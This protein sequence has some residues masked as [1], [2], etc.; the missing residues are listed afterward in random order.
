MQILQ[1]KA[2]QYLTE[3]V[4]PYIPGHSGLRSSKQLLLTEY[5]VRNQWGERSF[6]VAVARIWNSLPRDAKCT[7]SIHSF[8]KT[9]KTHLF[10]EAYK[11]VYV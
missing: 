10:N 5:P 3:L 4:Q 1:H 9:L 6:L 8:K 7:D 2:P 11:T